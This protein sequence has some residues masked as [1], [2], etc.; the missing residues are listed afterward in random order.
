[1]LWFILCKVGSCCCRKHLSCGKGKL[2]Y[3]KLWGA[4]PGCSACPI[5]CGTGSVFLQYSEKL[6]IQMRV[7]SV[8]VLL[9]LNLPIVGNNA[10]FSQLQLYYIFVF[11]KTQYEYFSKL[12]YTLNFVFLQRKHNKDGFSEVSFVPRKPSTN[13]GWVTVLMNHLGNNFVF[14]HSSK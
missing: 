11:Y 2:Q 14:Q 12:R 3:W 13:K 1:M 10:L 9:F 4:F 8:G 5:A 7:D 6:C